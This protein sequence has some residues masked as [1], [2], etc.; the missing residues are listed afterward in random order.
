MDH[1][2]KVCFLTSKE[3]LSFKDVQKNK[4]NKNI[5]FVALYY[6]F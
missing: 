5:K 4:K 2:L 6:I 1:Y 3:D